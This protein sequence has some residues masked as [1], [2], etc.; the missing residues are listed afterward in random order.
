MLLLSFHVQF[1]GVDIPDGSALYRKVRHAA[2]VPRQRSTS[3]PI[4]L[5]TNYLKIVAEKLQSIY[6]VGF[7]VVASRGYEYFDSTRCC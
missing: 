7:E 1:P 3:Q 4:A 5:N 6:I 2:N